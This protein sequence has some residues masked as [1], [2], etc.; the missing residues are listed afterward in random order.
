M[1][2]KTSKTVR[3]VSGVLLSA[4]TV[5]LGALFI[6]QVLDIYV[7]A[8]GVKP[9]FTRANVG[10]GLL[11]IL[12]AIIIWLVMVIA[13]FV[14]WEVFPV[15]Q[16][17][18][19]PDVRYTLYRLKKRM[20][21]TVG[22]ELKSSYNFVKAEEENLKILWIFC[23]VL[24]VA[25]IVYSIIYLANPLHF[26]NKNVT[27][28]MLN[29]VKNVM[30][31]ALAAFAAACGI[32]IYEGVSAKR[33]LERVKTLTAGVKPVEVVHGKIYKFFHHKYF[34]LGVRIAVGCVSVAFIIAG[35][36]NGSMRDVLIKA[37]NICTECIGLG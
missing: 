37:I 11:Q 13:A 27:H 26:P 23:A 7:S 20:P 32:C 35:I 31:W 28:E 22:E 14:L 30:P 6:W 17:R 5:I 15:P 19:K 1:K 25:G 24:G 29:M 34:V 9:I 8:G 10:D 12:P 21:A 4:M 33:Q 18:A 3:L 36:C 16:K 2:E